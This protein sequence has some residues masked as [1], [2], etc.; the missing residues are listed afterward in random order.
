M[1]TTL[2]KSW[3]DEFDV[4]ATLTELN[5]A[6]VTLH[7]PAIVICATLAVIGII[8]N[9]IVLSVYIPHPSS[10]S[11]VFIL[12][13]AVV[14]FIAC[15]V[16][17]PLLVF[18]MIHPY[19]FPSE[20][21]CKTL[22]FV[23]VFLVGTSVFIFVSIAIERHRA[24][25]IFE[26]VEMKTRRMHFMCIVS[27]I[28]GVV[29][30]VPAI[31]IYGVRT[32]KTGVHN[33][34]GTECFVE[35][36]F[37]QTDSIWPKIYFP[38]QSIVVSIS[39]ATLLVLYIRIGRQ[40]KW[41]LKFTRRYST[42]SI[43]DKSTKSSQS[44]CTQKDATSTHKNTAGSVLM[45]TTASEQ[46]EGTYRLHTPVG[47]A[48][49]NAASRVNRA[50]HEMTSMFCWLTAVFV[51]SFIPHL[52]F[53]IYSTFRPDFAQDMTSLQVVTYN[54]FLRSFVINNMANPLVYFACVSDFRRDFRN[55]ICKLFCC[56]RCSWT[57]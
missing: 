19:Q 44:L 47:K 14:D 29:V 36:H 34:T 56:C 53:I 21:V 5:D 52:A 40:L 27:C 50:A 12:W 22:R 10:F 46:T 41:H 35:D 15:S 49:S 9:L 43:L 25:C 37:I 23:H 13:L 39:F 11:R 55:L 7:L 45:K 38:F 30:A 28:M 26:L 18:S 8:G 42:S 48:A 24:I 57:K 51:L 32:V 33:I 4:N 16:G 3:R 6:L 2:P 20:N 54:I 31:F 17:T 1:Y